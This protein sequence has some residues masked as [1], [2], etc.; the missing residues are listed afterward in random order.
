VD[1][2][3]IAASNRDLPKMMEA[4]KFR[5]D[6]YYRLKVV[7]LH[8]PPLR[9]RKEDIPELVGLF[10]RNNNARMGMNIT[11]VTPRAMQALIAHDWP[12][13]IRELRNVIERAML[14]CDDPGI[15]L[16]HLPSELTSDST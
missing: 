12:G 8:L 7:D 13:N 10:I 16:P 14:F 4:A 11:D 15:D 9:Q 2:Q 3:I 5:E 1:V 6:L